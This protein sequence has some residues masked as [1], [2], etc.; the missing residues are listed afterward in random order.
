MGDLADDTVHATIT[1]METKRGSLILYY[2]ILY[3]GSKRSCNKVAAASSGRG[4]E[5]ETGLCLEE[6]SSAGLAGEWRTT[7]NYFSLEPCLSRTESR[8]SSP[9]RTLHLLSPRT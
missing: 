4:G 1:G 8:T 9:L 2:I 6:S 5:E 3:S 7:A